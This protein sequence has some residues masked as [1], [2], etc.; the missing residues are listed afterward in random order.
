MWLLIRHHYYSELIYIQEN[1]DPPETEGG[2]SA[3]EYGA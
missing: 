1:T 3:A 2:I